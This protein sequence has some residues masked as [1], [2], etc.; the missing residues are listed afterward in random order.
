MKQHTPTLQPQVSLLSGLLL[1]SGP[2]LVQ[3]PIQLPLEVLEPDGYTV[4]VSFPLPEDSQ[5]EA[6][7]LQ[8]HRPAYHYLS[9]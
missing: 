8:L 7:Y 9:H 3:A 6:L 1:L 2:T 4:S 5:A